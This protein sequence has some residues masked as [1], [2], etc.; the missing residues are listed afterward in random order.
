LA[1]WPE[2]RNCST[3][4]PVTADLPAP[5]VPV[6]ATSSDRDGSPGPTSFT[7][8]KLTGRPALNGLPYTTN[9]TAAHRQKL[10]TDDDAAARPQRNN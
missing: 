10:D 8:G 1:G 4:C 6:T 9:A 3:T 2:E 7:L 5:S